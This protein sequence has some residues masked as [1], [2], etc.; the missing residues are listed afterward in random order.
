MGKE[1][2]EMEYVW[3]VYED[4]YVSGVFRTEEEATIALKKIDDINA[5]RDFPARFAHSR[6]W[7]RRKIMTNIEFERTL[8]V[9]ST[10]NVKV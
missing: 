10:T 5:E 9:E 2:I 7:E 4:D 1:E 8:K 3:L 6:G